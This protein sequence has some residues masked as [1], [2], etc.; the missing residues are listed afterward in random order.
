MDQ[1]MCP[2]FEAAFEVLGKRW[3]GL[4]I[5]AL[6]SGAKRF[7]EIAD[8]IPN[9]SDRMLSERFRELEHGGIVCR[10]V[11]AEV[12]IRIEYTLSE[13]GLALEPIMDEV[14]RWADRWVNKE[15]DDT[16]AGCPS[17]PAP[18]ERPSSCG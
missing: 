5:R 8:I 1:T 18:D 14:Q 9:M 2:R 10:T 12:P 4:I 6:M 16:P 3:T 13:K 15:T 7:T 11:Y 17:S